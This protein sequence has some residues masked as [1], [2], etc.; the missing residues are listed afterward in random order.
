MAEP[1][2]KWAGGKRQILSQIVSHFPPEENIRG[3]HE[4]FFGGGAVFFRRCHEH[5]KTINDINTRLINFYKI[6]RDQPRELMSELENFERPDADPNPDRRFFKTNRKGKEIKS[7]YY[8]VREL[9]NRRPNEEEFDEV[10]EAA[11]LLYLN[12]TCYNGLYREN[13]SGEFNVPSGNYSNPDWE[14]RPRIREASEALESVE[15]FNADFSYVADCAEEED[16]VYCDPPYDPNGDA[17]T[18][19][20][21][22]SD[23]FG[24][25][26]QERLR[27]LALELNDQGVHVVISNA[28]SVGELYKPFNED[29][30]HVSEVGARRAINSNGD[31]RGEV[32]E[33]IVTNAD[34]LR[35]RDGTIPEFAF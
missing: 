1:I 9:F 8:Q 23:V 31:G 16:L 35:E 24:K 21:Y 4:P 33:V 12:R 3:Y 17:S 28:P 32:N 27:D 2:L 25:E 26:E 7:Y 10:E 15:I 30:F 11:Q 29:G 6:V 14:Q 34:Q 13:L 18:F 22:S 5:G 20:E 19:A